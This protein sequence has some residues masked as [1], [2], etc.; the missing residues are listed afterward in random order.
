MVDVSISQD[1][2][3]RCAGLLKHKEL[4]AI[5]AG[6][7]ILT[8]KIPVGSADMEEGVAIGV[9]SI[10]CVVVSVTTRGEDV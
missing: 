10:Y 5:V 9:A 6:I 2:A 8:W 7:S 4:F 3:T 1:H